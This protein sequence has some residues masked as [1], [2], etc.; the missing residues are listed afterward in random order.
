MFAPGPAQHESEITG[1]M[2]LVAAQR[3]QVLCEIG[4]QDGGNLLLMG[5]YLASLS[6]LI[7]VDLHIRNKGMLRSLLAAGRTPVFLEG[8]SYSGRMHERVQRVL[9]GRE[10][11]VLFIDGDHS[12]GGAARDFL[13]YRRFVRDGGFIGFHDIVP[14]RRGEACAGGSDAYAGDVPVLWN[15]L[16]PLFEH[17]EFVESPGQLGRGIGA[18]VHRPEVEGPLLCESLPDPRT[19]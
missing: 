9:D 16:K 5:R 2:K 17:Y 11:D 15:E 4:T 14:D 18:I 12:Y 1:F 3:P 13:L 10:I 7:G 8:S 6:L 19:A